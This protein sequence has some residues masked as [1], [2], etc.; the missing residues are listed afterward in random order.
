MQNHNIVR[1]QDIG[2][3]SLYTINTYDV[4]ITY[5]YQICIRIKVYP[6]ASRMTDFKWERVGTAQACP[7][8]PNAWVGN[9]VWRRR[10]QGSVEGYDF[11]TVRKPRESKSSEG[12]EI[13]VWLPNSPHSALHNQIYFSKL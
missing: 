5:Q 13:K 4:I 1:N 11:A 9:A 6:I 8:C 7:T 2:R 10:L 3:T 12:P